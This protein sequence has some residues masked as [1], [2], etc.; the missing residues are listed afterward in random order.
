VL[1]VQDVAEILKVCP[2]TV[3]NMVKRGEIPATRIGH[4]WRFDEES[5]HNW[6]KEKGNSGV[7]N[8]WRRPVGELPESLISL[9]NPQQIHIERSA[10]TKRQVLEDLAALAVKSGRISSYNALLDSLIQREEMFSTALD[11]GVAFPHPRRPMAGLKEPILAILVVQSG[12][13][14]GAPGGGRTFL[15]IF[16]CAPDDVTHVRI[17]ARL[18]RLFHNQRRLVSKLR[19]I[20]SASQIFK[21]LVVA[22]K[23]AI[24]AIKLSG[25]KEIKYV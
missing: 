10:V 18:A 14:F 1:T 12:V 7:V 22:E 24:E 15:F 4:L 19:H 20:S 23:K 9:V 3:L 21:E 16:F 2:R 25:E 11:A 5:I 8:G 13:D 17:L 6:L